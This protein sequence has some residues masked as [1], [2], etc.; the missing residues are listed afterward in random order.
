MQDQ[1]TA[2]NNQ[3]DG[4]VFTLLQTLDQAVLAKPHHYYRAMRENDS[5]YWDPYM[6]A[7]VVTGYAEVLEVITSYSSDRAPTP[8]HLE[9]LGLDF[10]KPFAEMMTQQMLFMDAPMHSRLRALCTTAFTPSK[11]DSLRT[12]IQSITDELIDSSIERGHM[13]LIADFSLHLPAIVTANL[14]GVPASDHT[15]LGIWVSDIAEVHGNFQHHP[16]RVSTILQ[17]LVDMKGYV[18]DRMNELRLHPNGGLISSLMNADVNGQKLTDDEV[19]AT[20]IVTMIGGHETTTNL[21]ASGFLTLLENP[22]SLEQLRSKPEIA[23]SAIEE[24]LRFESPVQHTARIAP[25]D[26]VLGKKQI[27]KGAKVVAVLAAANRD[28]SRFAD[29]DKL[30]LLRSDNRHLAFG[31]ASH[32]CFGAPL[33]RMETQIAFATL[34]RRIHEPALSESPLRWRSNSGLRGLNSLNITFRASD[35]VQSV[36]S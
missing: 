17:S 30:D 16:T 5:V 20:T 21:I 32:F 28:P 27:R 23:G 10:M 24:L 34:L 18:K 1:T 3:P 19:V 22:A 6:H 12:A 11:V 9:E 13:D 8:A 29:P 25:T 36:R 33:A 4:K 14:M 26:S 7:W 35:R 31:W 2:K 15:Q